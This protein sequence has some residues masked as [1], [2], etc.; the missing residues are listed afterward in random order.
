MSYV[1]SSLHGR[2]DRPK[3]NGGFLKFSLIFIFVAI[4]VVLAVLGVFASRKYVENRRNVTNIKDLYKKMY[5]NK[6]YLGLIE[7]MDFELKRKPMNIEYMIY[8]GFS[9]HLLGESEKDLNKKNVYF[10]LALVDLRKAVAIGLPDK[11]AS[12]VYFCIGKIYYY[13][14]RTYYNQSINYLKLSLTYGNERVDLLYILGLVYSYV[15]NYEE[16]NKVLE[17]S[18]D[19]EKSELVMLALGINEMR[20][21]KNASA[22]SYFEN[23]AKITKNAKLKEKSLFNIGVILFNENNFEKSLEM[24]NKVIEINE[25]NAEAYY[26]RGE[27]YFVYY[28]DNI[29]ARSEWRKTLEIDP[30]HI[31]AYKRI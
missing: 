4:V 24:F 9:Y 14:G 19:I 5:A 20:L 13:L 18:L 16:S 7:K 26:Y 22:K 3:N 10:S 30:S 21:D 29:R 25:N 6:N 28:R 8:R 1:Y 31:K 23:V 12:D 2:S 17:R 27:I 15:G 11:I